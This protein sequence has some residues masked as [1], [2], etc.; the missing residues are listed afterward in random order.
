MKDGSRER[1]L[2]LNKKVQTTLQFHLQIPSETPHGLY[3]Y[4]LTYMLRGCPCDAWFLKASVYP[5]P[6]PWF[7]SL[8]IGHA[9]P[10]IVPRTMQSRSSDV[11]ASYSMKTR[12]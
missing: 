3:I 11:A 12:M 4:E 8:L 6:P 5:G 9:N 10:E 2:F 1:Y 7:G